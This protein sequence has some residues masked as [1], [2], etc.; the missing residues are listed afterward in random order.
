[1]CNSARV[2][3]DILVLFICLHVA[4]THVWALHSHSPSVY[5]TLEHTFDR[6]ILFPIRLRDARSYYCHRIFSFIIAIYVMLVH[7]VF[8]LV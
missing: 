3:Q 6:Y 5:V 2:I 4:R 1:M 7:M 8:Q